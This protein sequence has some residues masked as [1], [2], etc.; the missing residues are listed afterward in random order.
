LLRRLKPTRAVRVDAS[1]ALGLVGSITGVSGLVLAWQ[2]QREESEVLLAA[3][4]SAGRDDLTAEGFGLRMEVVN[5]SL[6]PVIVRS[7]DLVLDGEV[8]AHASAYLDDPKVLDSAR[9][10]PTLIS[11]RSRPFPIGLGARS[12]RSLVVVMD[13]WRPVARAETRRSN[14]LRGSSWCAC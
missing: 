5:A 2:S 13:V 11:D 3:Y 6:R 9:A 8:V 14:R 10:N 12:G 7:A 4:A 1:I